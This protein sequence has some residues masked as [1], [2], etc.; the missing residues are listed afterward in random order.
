MEYVLSVLNQGEFR[1]EVPAH[2]RHEIMGLR[3]LGVHLA[4]KL[5]GEES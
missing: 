1:R 2:L 5:F 3:L 4:E